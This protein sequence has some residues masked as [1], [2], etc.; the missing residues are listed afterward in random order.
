MLSIGAS[1][2]AE[3]NHCQAFIKK[4]RGDD[5]KKSQ[6]RPMRRKE[7]AGFGG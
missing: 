1:F 6:P 4:K 3:K 7:V 2:A 5:R